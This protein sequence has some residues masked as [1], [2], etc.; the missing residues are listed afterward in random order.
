MFFPFA[1][2]LSSVQFLQTCSTTS[3]NNVLFS[4]VLVGSRCINI[5]MPENVS[6]VSLSF[7]ELCLPR[8]ARPQTSHAQADILG[9]R[10]PDQSVQHVVVLVT[11]D[12]VSPAEGLRVRRSMENAIYFA[13]YPAVQAT[14]VGTVPQSGH[15][16]KLSCDDRQSI[17]RPDQVSKAFSSSLFL[18]AGH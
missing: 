12:A 15:F 6:R 11:S 7:Q 16:V 5:G 9:G 2:S 4:G 13:A 10:I 17:R 14:T 3:S 1:Y 18:V 8:F